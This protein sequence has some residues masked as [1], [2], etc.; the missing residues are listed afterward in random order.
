MTPIGVRRPCREKA[1]GDPARDSALIQKSGCGS[2]LSAIGTSGQ[3]QALVGA[4]RGHARSHRDPRDGDR[5]E[6]LRRL[7][8]ES[9]R[10]GGHVPARAP[11]RGRQ[12][13][14]CPGRV[15]AA[16]SGD[17]FPGRVLR[18][19]AVRG[20]MYGREGTRTA[21]PSLT[22]RYA[23]ASRHLE[24]VQ[25]CRIHKALNGPSGRDVQ[26][27]PAGN[28]LRRVATEKR[29]GVGG[30]ATGVG[31]AGIRSRR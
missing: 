21:C 23:H 10:A 18:A 24:Q 11:A 5:S 6:H 2:P 31:Q 7:R 19:E 9:L 17:G 22:L 26:G 28:E 16:R 15:R 30:R 1:I 27:D 14:A 4:R 29:E 20:V 12:A 8:R 25:G 3:R 13:K